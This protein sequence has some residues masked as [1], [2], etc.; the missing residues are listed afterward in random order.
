MHWVLVRLLQWGVPG[1]PADRMRAAL[2]SH[3]TAPALAAEAAFFARAEE[4]GNERPYG[5]GWLLTL[6]H[7]LAVWADA[8]AARWAEN[9]RPLA[10]VFVDRFVEWL[11]KATYPVRHGVHGNSA[12]ALSLA[13]PAAAS[14]PPTAGP[15]CATRSRD[16][17][18]A[19][20][21]RRPR[22]SRPAGALRGRLPLRPC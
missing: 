17:G 1:L 14:S 18:P 2:S 12:F 10:G 21:R 11:P 16:C 15:S 20:V 22:R 5:W 9:V 7:D 3:L 13:L 19:L 6:H 8:D 4:R